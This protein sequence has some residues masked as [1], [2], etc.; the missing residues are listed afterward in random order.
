MTPQE[1]ALHSKVNAGTGRKLTK[2][3]QKFKMRNWPKGKVT[4]KET[5]RL[6]SKDS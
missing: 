3:E 2:A 5:H 1:Q 4:I 6:M